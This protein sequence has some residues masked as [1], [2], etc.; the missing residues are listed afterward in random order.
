MHSSVLSSKITI[1][2]IIYFSLRI[3]RLSSHNLWLSHL[4]P[5]VDSDLICIGEI[6][7][8]SLFTKGIYHPTITPLKCYPCFDIRMVRL[9]Q[10]KGDDWNNVS[11]LLWVV[12]FQ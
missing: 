7:L 8:E 9:F 5:L 3:P 2:D 10:G 11:R 4:L 6:V 12:Y 1:T